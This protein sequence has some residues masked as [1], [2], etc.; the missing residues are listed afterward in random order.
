MEK[1]SDTSIALIV[2]DEGMNVF[3]MRDILKSLEISSDSTMVST[4]AIQLVEDRI[5]KVAQGTA[6]MYKLLLLDYSMPDLDGIELVQK[7]R[8]LVDASEVC[9]E[10][11]IYCC[12]TAYDT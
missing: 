12:C 6:V 2:D 9:K 11:P 4:K 5:A 10:Q 7:L 8:A 3:C 1:A